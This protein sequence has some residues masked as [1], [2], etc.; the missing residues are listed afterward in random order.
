M[1]RKSLLALALLTLPAAAVEVTGF[2]TGFPVPDGRVYSNDELRRAAAV[3]QDFYSNPANFY[4]DRKWLAAACWWL[5]E[6]L[7]Q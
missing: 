6:K 3:C 4:Q 7:K 1:R 5:K 2:P